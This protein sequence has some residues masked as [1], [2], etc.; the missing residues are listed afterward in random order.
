[1]MT[2]FCLLVLVLTSSFALA[3]A[4]DPLLRTGCATPTVIKACGFQ[5]RAEALAQRRQYPQAIQSAT[6]AIAEIELAGGDP[7]YL[8]AARSYVTQLQ[9]ESGSAQAR[10]A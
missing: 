1:T 3:S 8:Q 7:F 2:N 5:Y 4:P 9:A 10:K 6:L